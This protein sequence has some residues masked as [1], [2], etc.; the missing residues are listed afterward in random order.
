MG[1]FVAQG[2]GYKFWYLSSNTFDNGINDE[3][4][5]Y[6]EDGINIVLAGTNPQAALQTVDKGVKQVLDK[7]TKPASTPSGK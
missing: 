4:I 3:M 1:A 2:P 5:K 7:Y 6:F